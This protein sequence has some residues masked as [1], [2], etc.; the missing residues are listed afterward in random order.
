MTL[1]PEGRFEETFFEFR[2]TIRSLEQRLVGVL[3]SW[4][5]LCPTVLAELRVLELFQGLLRREA[6]QVS[7]YTHLPT[8]PLTSGW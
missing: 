1:E 2:S 5:D 4:F 3:Q 8:L 7:E 6:V